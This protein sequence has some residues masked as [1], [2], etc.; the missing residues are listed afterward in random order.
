MNLIEKLER[1][2]TNGAV[3]FHG[4]GGNGI[5]RVMDAGY[6]N[7]KFWYLD[8]AD[9]F[10]WFPCKLEDAGGENLRLIGLGTS[11][12]AISQAEELLTFEAH[13]AFLIDLKGIA[14]KQNREVM[15]NTL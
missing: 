2:V 4:I 14:R 10:H 13:Q 12:A 8:A 11:G 5:E 6:V 7:G 9:H 1:I 15:E 3:V